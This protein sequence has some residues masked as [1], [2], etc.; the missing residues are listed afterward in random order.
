MV[1]LP[2]LDPNLIAR[3]LDLE[4][5]AI[6]N[7]SE[8]RPLSESTNL[9]EPQQ[10]V[11]AWLRNALL[12]AH[13]E[14]EKTLRDLASRRS[15]I[16]IRPLIGVL[17][18][19]ESEGRIG[20]DRARADMRGELK[21]LA[22]EKSVADARARAFRRTNRLHRSARYPDSNI[23]HWAMI[24][25]VVMSESAANSYF[26]AQDSDLGLL[27]G[28]LQ[29]LLISVVNI[30]IALFCGVFGM[31]YIHHVDM[32]GRIFGCTVTAI[33]SVVTVA[34]NLAVAHYR[35]ALEIDP[36]SAL[37]MVFRSL[38]SQ[39]FTIDNFDAGLLL[40]IGLLSSAFAMVKSYNADDTYPGYGRLDRE[41]KEAGVAYENKRQ[42][43]R[44]RISAAIDE[45][46]HEVSQLLANAHGYAIEFPGTVA[47]TERT[48]GNFRRFESECDEALRDLLDRYR[49]ANREIRGTREPSYF[50]V[51]PDFGV[52]T[53]LSED[54]LQSARARSELIG[55]ELD[56][57]EKEA[58][59]SYSFLTD[60]N[61]AANIETDRFLEGIE[62]EVT[63]G[64]RPLGAA[65]VNG[66]SSDG[67]QSNEG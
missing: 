7:G 67:A 16:A 29:A 2:R 18:T 57:F 32:P 41:T 31:R 43:L 35:V 44:D 8:K 54:D 51:Y 56:D 28:L 50:A 4:Q 59:N 64:G 24:A 12:T 9:D 17:R 30:G 66:T 52:N 33:Y 21:F 19:L 55:N 26:F 62:T 38:T 61:T 45:T 34:L 22:E 36:V 60:L 53:E 3:E 65:D 14:T 13:G 15:A 49:V 48:I 23:M 27:G 11:L 37:R 1:S 6:N 40:M 5:R 46:R 47:E 10:E 42:E 39:P 63:N 20:V 58:K 25:A